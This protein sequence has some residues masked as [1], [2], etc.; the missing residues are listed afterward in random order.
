MVVVDKGKR[1]VQFSIPREGRGNDDEASTSGQHPEDERTVPAFLT[2]RKA[3]HFG[4][5]GPDF[6]KL[7]KQNTALVYKELIPELSRIRQS[8]ETGSDRLAKDLEESVRWVDPVDPVDYELARRFPIKTRLDEENGVDFAS[9]PERPPDRSA[10]SE[11]RDESRGLTRRRDKDSRAERREDEP[12]PS[13]SKT[14]PGRTRTHATQYDRGDTPANELAKSLAE[15]KRRQENREIMDS[16]RPKIREIRDY[17]VGEEVPL[18]SMV[19]AAR[20]IGLPKPV[21]EIRYDDSVLS[22]QSET[23]RLL[24]ALKSMQYSKLTNA[25]RKVAPFRARSRDV[26]AELMQNQ[27]EMLRGIKAKSSKAA[28]MKPPAVGVQENQW[29]PSDTHGNSKNKYAHYHSL[30]RRGRYVGPLEQK[31]VWEGSA[32]KV[33]L[34]QDLS[35]KLGLKVH[36]LQWKAAHDSSVSLNML[37]QASTNKKSSAMMRVVFKELRNLVVILSAKTVDS[38]I[39]IEKFVIKRTLR[40]WLAFC[41]REIDLRSRLERFVL[42][43]EVILRRMVILHWTRLVKREFLLRQNMKRRILSQWRKHCIWVGVLRN[44]TMKR[45]LS[46][47]GKY[48]KREAVLRENFHTVFVKHQKMVKRSALFAWVSYCDRKFELHRKFTELSQAH[49]DRMKR[50]VMMY[51]KFMVLRRRIKQV[52]LGLASVFYRMRKLR[53]VVSAWMEVISRMNAFR[54]ALYSDVS[55]SI[56]TEATL[57]K[58]KV[59]MREASKKLE[60]TVSQMKKARS[61]LMPKIR[62]LQDIQPTLWERSLEG[63]GSSGQGTWRDPRDSTTVEGVEF[64]RALPSEEEQEDIEYDPSGPT[65]EDLAGEDAPRALESVRTERRGTSTGAPIVEAKSYDAR[66]VTQRQEAS[67]SAPSTLPS[68]SRPPMQQ[69][70]SMTEIRSQYVAAISDAPIVEAKPYGVRVVNQ[71]QEASISAPSPLPSPSRPTTQQGRS[72]AEIRS[73]YVAAITGMIPELNEAKIRRVS[74]GTTP[75]KGLG[76][77]DATNQAAEDPVESRD[78]STAT[79]ATKLMS[80]G[81]TPVKGL[82]MV[83]AAHQAAEDPVDIRDTAT[84]TNVTASSLIS[85]GTT[86]VKGL[87]MVDATNQAAEDPVESREMA[88]AT[89]TTAMTSAGTSPLRAPAMVDATNQAAEDPVES[90]DIATSTDT[91]TSTEKPPSSVDLATHA[92]PQ[93]SMVSAGTSPVKA[94]QMDDATQSSL[95]SA[96]TSPVKG[97]PMADITHQVI[98]DPIES[99]DIAPSTGIATS[100][101]EPQSPVE[102]E[103]EGKKELVSASTSP[104]P[105]MIAGTDAMPSDS[106]QASKEDASEGRSPKREKP[107][108]SQ[109]SVFM[110]SFDAVLAPHQERSTEAGTPGAVPASPTPSL[111]SI[112]SLKELAEGF[113]HRNLYRGIIRAIKLE[114]ARSKQARFLA[115]ESYKWHVF[116]YY[117]I[118]WYHNVVVVGRIVTVRGNRVLKSRY[119]MA[120][121]G[122]AMASRN[123]RARAELVEKAHQ[124]QIMRSAFKICQESFAKA[125]VLRKNLAE[126]N[127]RERAVKRHCKKALHIWRLWSNLLITRRFAV[128][129]VSFRV[130]LRVKRQCLINWWHFVQSEKLLKN[131]LK[132]TR[133]VSTVPKEKVEI[134]LEKTFSLLMRVLYSWRH[135]ILSRRGKP[136]LKAG[137]PLFVRK[138]LGEIFH[139]GQLESSRGQSQD[140]K[141]ACQRMFLLWY[142]LVKNVRS[143]EES[144][145]VRKKLQKETKYRTE[146]Q[147]YRHKLMK[148]CLLLLKSAVMAKE[149]TA[150]KHHAH[151]VCRRSLGGW[152]DHLSKMKNLEALA[153]QMYSKKLAAFA[154][155]N[156]SMSVAEK[157]VA[158]KIMRLRMMSTMNAW[159]LRAVESS[160]FEHWRTKLLYGVISR[161]R[162]QV[163]TEEG[164]EGEC[165]STASG[166]AKETSNKASGPPADLGRRLLVGQETFI[167]SPSGELSRPGAQVI[168]A[169]ALARFGTEFE[170]FSRVSD[171][172]VSS[173]YV[174]DDIVGQLEELRCQWKLEELMKV[175]SYVLGARFQEEV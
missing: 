62:L 174:S 130:S 12:K 83:D 90:H 66:V 171:A 19:E 122:F 134:T 147:L 56:V 43:H 72:M 138:T 116:R 148:K 20:F 74:A 6:R 128:M 46:Q 103:T 150:R 98:D 79:N 30:I 5:D 80:A 40:I 151:R 140:S 71:R 153:V 127:S 124:I 2:T 73:Q 92:A 163:E 53:M 169:S 146:Y 60:K 129:R 102:F 47:W 121:D 70:R 25:G 170:S 175:R 159:N 104:M 85:A 38:V 157:T 64:D 95:V 160:A 155:L 84:I 28:S 59:H 16:I 123:L 44:H 65:L 22:L 81:T 137:T 41:K 26:E 99:Q 114:I 105:S 172:S 110:P 111:P 97:P 115:Q 118:V 77:V 142:L 8:L 87:G 52:N 4:E 11:A 154:L 93:S 17:L 158:K 48:S 42:E 94:S 82:G 112:R 143:D 50:S 126:F 144:A 89:N 139:M 117:L 96:G 58:N 36:F 49:E 54:K 156:W 23:L 21:R 3:S 33:T 18:P 135:L 101:E 61:V 51:W 10:E 161:W 55:K 88:T 45:V 27:K 173:K 37:I 9:V 164:E 149:E 113:Y 86:P 35:T 78:M 109:L 136:D 168:D 133:R 120:W 75:V 57:D 67:T 141:D 166:A 13:E 39:A 91:V 14:E 29:L 7:G 125:K 162:S 32:F 1:K 145:R 76:M 165:E 15:R 68:P 108:G 132:Q 69:G 31:S 106:D 24:R 100:T 119:F 107:K 63:E 131:V 34:L 167:V 152:K